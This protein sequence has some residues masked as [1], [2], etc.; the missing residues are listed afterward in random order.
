MGGGRKIEIERARER[1]RVVESF[2]VK[3]SDYA[4]VGVISIF[5]KFFLRPAF[6]PSPQKFILVESSRGCDLSG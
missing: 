4:H 1:E 3:E 5:A 2:F 6:S